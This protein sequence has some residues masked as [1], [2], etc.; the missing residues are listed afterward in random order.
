MSCAQ[1][2]SAS[3]PHDHSQPFLLLLFWA[4]NLFTR[5]N[6]RVFFRM[7]RDHTIVVHVDEELYRQFTG[8]LQAEQ[9]LGNSE[10][11]NSS[12]GK[13]I[14]KSFVER[15]RVEFELLSDVFH[16]NEQNGENDA[17]E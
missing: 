6:P 10:L 17:S 4:G 8:L 9:Q 16:Q 7:K 14:I 15:R 13:N 12:F 11:C 1:T 2:Y 5:V 3:L